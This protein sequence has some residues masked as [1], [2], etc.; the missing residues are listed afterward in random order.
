[1]RDNEFILRTMVNFLAQQP[2]APP[3]PRPDGEFVIAPL[4]MLL[5]D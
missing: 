1:M 4:L 2:S 3:G 5:S